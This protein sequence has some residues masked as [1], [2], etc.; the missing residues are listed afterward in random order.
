MSVSS[1]M[2]VSNGKLEPNKIPGGNASRDVT[3][4]IPPVHARYG[5][6]KYP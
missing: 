1:V 2:S 3:K 4:H 6:I 5:V